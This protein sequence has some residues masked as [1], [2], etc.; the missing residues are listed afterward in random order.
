MVIKHPSEFL[1][2]VGVLSWLDLPFVLDQADQI[3]SYFLGTVP[4]FGDL[5]LVFIASQKQP[6]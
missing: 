4:V 1:R 3:V 2:R 5:S 6:L